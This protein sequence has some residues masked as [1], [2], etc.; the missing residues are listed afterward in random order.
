MNIQILR[1]VRQMFQGYYV[2][3]QTKRSYQLKWVR[4][5]RNL[6]DKYL[7]AKKVERIQWNHFFNSIENS[8]Q[9][10]CIAVIALK[11]RVINGIAAKRIILLNL[12]TWI[13]KIKKRS[14]MKS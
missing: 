14:S 11:Q 2:D 4:S 13:L 8:F 9:I 6:G 10:F 3:E 12:K 1:H 7:L 5:V